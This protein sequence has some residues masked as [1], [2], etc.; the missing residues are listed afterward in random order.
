MFTKEK[1]KVRADDRA[2]ER[3]ALRVAFQQLVL[4]VLHAL[5]HTEQHG[6]VQR[7]LVFKI[8]VEHALVDLRQ[9][10][11]L[12]DARAV[13]ALFGKLLLR[14]LQNILL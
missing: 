7:L 14:R 8:L 11:D 12:V 1:I 13:K 9:R 4:G 3:D 5:V 2:D 10:S 6:L